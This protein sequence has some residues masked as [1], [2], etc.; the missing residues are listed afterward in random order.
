VEPEIEKKKK[1]KEEKGDCGGI[2]G[3]G[4][5]RRNIQVVISPNPPREAGTVSPWSV[6]Y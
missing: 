6:L 4:E 1:R 3:S 2:R 5:I